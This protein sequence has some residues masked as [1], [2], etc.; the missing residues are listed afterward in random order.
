MERWGANDRMGDLMF[1]NWVGLRDKYF[2][3]IVVKFYVQDI[4]ML[5]L[6]ILVVRSSSVEE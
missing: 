3:V 5:R 4:K 1:T 6:E 2:D